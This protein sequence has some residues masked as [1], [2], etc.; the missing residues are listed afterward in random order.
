MKADLI[1]LNEDSMYATEEPLR[2]ELLNSEQ[3]ERHTKRFADAHVLSLKHGHDKL[4]ARL[5][6]NEQILLKVHELL[7]QAVTQRHVTTPAGEWL[8]DNFYLIEDQIRFTK[9]HLPR[10]YSEKLTQLSSGASK[11]LPRVY[12]IALEIISHSDGRIDIGTLS[13]VVKAYQTVKPISLGELWAVPIMLRLALIENLRRV[14]THIATDRINRNLADYWAKR[15]ITA[16]DSEPKSLILVVADMARS[17]PP[18]ERAFVAEL[19]RQLRGK[20]HTLAQALSWIEDRLSELG[21]SSNELVQSE[22]Q[23]QA[24]HQVSVSNSIGSLRLVSSMD[25]RDFV[26]DNSSVEAILRT[27]PSYCLMDFSTR[28]QYRH[29][30]EHIAKYS[31]RSEDQVAQIASDLATEQRTTTPSNLREAHVGYYLLGKGR[32]ATELQSGMKPLVRERVRRFFARYPLSTYSSSV[33]FFTLTLSTALSYSAFMQGNDGWTLALT[34]LLSL[35]C[36]SQ[37]AL[38]VVNFLASLVVQPQLLARMD[39]TSGLPN[40]ARTLVVIPAMLNSMEDIDAMLEVLEVRFLANNDKN[41]LFGLITD[42]LD[43]ETEHCDDDEMLVQHL[44]EGVEDLNSKYDNYDHNLFFLFHRPRRYNAHDKLWM[45]FERK[46]GKLEEL[47]GLLRG[48][49]VGS[50]SLVVGDL[51]LAQTVAYIITLD[52]D[53][54][55]PRDA[56]RKMVGSINHPLNRPV[57]DATKQ[58]VVEGYG[59]LQPRVSTTLPENESTRYARLNGNDPGIDPYTRATSDVYQDLFEEGSFIGKGIYDVDMFAL[60]LKNKFPV[61]TILSHDLL[62]GCY[63]RSGLLSDVQVFEKY[64]ERYLNDARRRH[65][66]VRGDWQIAVWCLPFVPDINRRWHRN[67]LS[68]LS[69]WKIIDN[70]R[71]SV[72]PAAFSLLLILGWTLLHN[73]LFW[74]LVVTAIF[75]IPDVV[76]SL[77]TAIRKPHDINLVAH[78]QMSLRSG[79]N[80]AA[81]TS[82]RMICLPYEAWTNLDAIVRTL[83]RLV[84]SH[85]S[86]LQWTPSVNIERAKRDSLLQA[87]AQMWIEPFIA[88]CLAVWFVIHSPEVLTT[89]ALILLCWICSPLL[90]W[91]IS[92]PL[93]F[94]ASRL[95]RAEVGFLRQQARKTWLYFEDFVTAS[96]NWLPPDNVQEHPLRVV[97]HR[98]SPTNMGLALLATVSAAEFGYISARQLIERCTATLGT[99]SRLDRYQGHF[100]NWYD[101][102]SLRVLWPRYISTVDSGNLAAHLITLRQAL[103]KLPDTPI[104]SLDVFEGLHDTLSILAESVSAKDIAS[105]RSI[106]HH[107]DTLRTTPLVNLSDYY[108]RLHSLESHSTSILNALVYDSDSMVERWANLVS[109]TIAEAQ[110]ELRDLVP[111][112][113]HD[114][115]DDQ[116]TSAGLFKGIPT[117]RDIAEVIEQTVLSAAHHSETDSHQHTANSVRNLT[118][119]SPQLAIER[120]S[121]LDTLAAQCTEMSELEFDF[122]YNR[123]KHLLTV[124]YNV[125]EHRCDNSFYDLLASEARLAT[126]VGIAQGRLPQESWFALGRLLTN[127]GGRPILLSWGGSMF[128]Y[129]MPFLVMPSYE[130]TL[131]DQTRLAVVEQ[132]IDYAK[133]RGVVWGMSE[134]GYNMVDSSLNYQYQ[135]FGVPKLGIKRGLEKDIVV[136]PY[137]SA[138]ALMV[139]PEKACENMQHMVVDGYESHYGLYEA[140]DFTPSRVPRGQFNVIVQSYMSHHLGMTL[141]S[142]LFV[143]RNR[144]M[145]RLFEADPRFQAT[146]LLLQERIPKVT[147]FF[148]HTSNTAVLSPSVTEADIRVL[149]SPNTPIPE[150]QLL[151]NGNYHVMLS[152]SG[153]GYSRWRD[154]AV[155]RW[156]EDALDDHYGNF[157]YVRDLDTGEYWSS[158]YQPTLQKGRQFEAAFSQ[159]RADFRVVHSHLDIRTEIVVSPEDDIEMRR[160]HLSNR[161]SKHRSID[162]TSCTEVVIAP[163]ANDVIHPA[164]SNLFVQTE[165]DQTKSAIIATRRAR[166]PNEKQPWMFHIMNIHDKDVQEVSFETDRM[167]FIGRGNSTAHPDAMKL[168]GS[169]S[170][171]EG[172]VLDPIVS[173]RKRL[174]LAPDE[175]IVIDMVIGIAESAELCRN[176]IDKYQDMHHKD[177]VFELAW[178]H[179]QVVLRQ[180]NASEGDAQL[181]C[182]LANSIIFMNPSLRADPSLLIKNRRGQA[183]LWPYAI[184]GDLPIVLLMIEDQADIALVQQLIQAHA[185]WRLKGLI[186]D[187]VIWNDSH[188]G[189]RQDLQ[190]QIVGLISAQNNEQ[191][192]AIFVRASEQIT[193]EDRILFQTVA[194]AIIS[195]SGGTLADHVNRKTAPKVLI[196]FLAPTQPLLAGISSLKVPND[197][198][199]YNGIGGFNA[200]GKEYVI[201]THKSSMTPAPW[202][203]VIANANFGSVI[204]ECGQAYTWSE[205]A[206][207]MRLTPWNNDP[208]CDSG[209]EAI[210][211]RDEQSGHFWSATTLPTHSRSPYITRHGF[212]YSSFEHEEAGIHSELLV[213]VDLEENIKCSIL[214]LTNKSERPRRLSVT[215]YVELVLGDLRSKTYRSVITEIDRLTG[216]LFARN[217]YNSEFAHRVAF[218]DAEGGTKSYTADRTEFVGR[219]S[220]LSNPSALSRSKLSDRV[221]AG[222]DPCAAIQISFELSENQHHEVAFRLG[223]GL[224]TGDAQR[225]VNRF[226]GMD[227]M[228]S[229]LSRVHDY[230][231]HSNLALQISTPDAALN[232]MTNGWLRYQTVSSRLFA[233]SGYYQ[234]G[235]AF[236][237][238]DQ[239]QDVLSIMDADAPM[240]RKQIVLSASRQYREG[241]VQH[242]WHAPLERGVRTRCSDDYLWLPY[243]CARYLTTTEDASILDE[244]IHFLEGRLL[245][246]NEQSY[247]DVA[248]RSTIS[249]SMYQ[250]CVLSIRHALRFGTHGLALIGSG[251]WNDGMDNVGPE[252]LGESVW[253]SFFLY[254]ILIKFIPIALAKN[255]KEF[256]ALCEKQASTL[257]QNIE[258]HAWDGKWYRRA[259]FDDGTALGSAQNQDCK[260]DSIAQS[261]SLLSGAATTERSLMALSSA[262]RNLV[263]PD[264]QLIQ[265]LQ[266]PFDGTLPHPGY[267]AGYVPGVREN[268]GQYTH[269]AVWLIMALAQSGKS[270]QAWQMLSM[271]NPINH[272]RHEHQIDRYKVEPYV[273][274]ADVYACEPHVGRGGWTWYTGAAGWMN[275]LIS[276]SLLGLHREGNQLKLQPHLFAAWSGI[277]LSYR[278]LSSY[279]DISITT[280]AEADAI[281]LTIDNV[282]LVDKT[283]MCVPLVDDGRRHKVALRLHSPT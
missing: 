105:L 191:S 264:A 196:P 44:R 181:Y 162:I 130:N 40:E 180:I 69:R 134:S 53:T 160:V 140:I 48:N 118:L 135:T 72:S 204:S 232:I 168:S 253:L 55:L 252:G 126:F 3:M 79:I 174:T 131:L 186:V 57:Y 17:N 169:L 219:N 28:D 239:L 163:Q 217:P 103:L 62:E 268:G 209:S 166:Y 84:I 263:Q 88:L 276:E 152:N 262:V 198:Q 226:R 112:A 120:I 172:S 58:R 42:F 11:G 78:I 100:Y 271:I 8:M 146:L 254:D 158:T 66:W 83:W 227:A 87:V 7:I 68:A 95:S 202:S 20:G 229:S 1:G 63:A 164:F 184:S 37:L 127:A 218:F 247:Y 91:F 123:T 240:A 9:K 34:L 244:D 234:S 223:Q 150:V 224:N 279:Y 273:V 141:L 86:L 115:M 147:S 250:H 4:L 206:H 26:E 274:S 121:Q 15:M 190:N 270:Q 149:N 52:I 278:Y 133:Q 82:L 12:D 230:W 29:V 24:A 70:L 101:T 132:Q 165:I 27:D 257:Q 2:S 242:W 157:C 237:F 171:T 176:L 241:D 275:Q 5:A 104:A 243:V 178:T 282:E 269:A 45:G 208:V 76:S 197:I 183:G 109:A 65:R 39:Y 80:T 93:H 35:L 138:L 64:P 97:A 272:A 18:L 36:S 255:D 194:R 25:W 98:T 251:D 107:I 188:S 161:S 139:L 99:M 189:Y 21:Q 51:A 143:L 31:S 41:I 277:E 71:R 261:W 260:I 231:E 281:G 111:G 30:V 187:L 199:F 173:I 47:N 59:I 201:E 170:G 238:R 235:G 179:N 228:T 110:Q 43:A 117:L 233:R 167:K 182:R 154:I 148:A 96:E 200:N 192:G 280:V 248:T 46:R 137:A 119:C 159:G 32:S 10:V 94:R 14:C 56:A 256:A 210:Y 142:I 259:Y 151:S 155:T 23:K 153:S 19:S 6:K 75:I 258:A 114:S 283:D 195:T 73:A 216:S 54:Q 136:A 60:A 267:I 61:N 185:Y 221:G 265:L 205:N 102:Q 113:T 74:T 214:K 50:F 245:S 145:Q 124:G 175:T 22:N 106:V 246:N 220:S 215:G 33:L 77:W 125:D 49:S 203:N 177:R 211:I 108:Q 16:A 236:G 92:Q 129:L 13:A 207:E 212:G 144:P 38:T 116:E 122:L 89:S 67:T 156:R 90:C 225:I 85:K 193:A 222:L 266:P 128:E 249:R 81:T 213:F